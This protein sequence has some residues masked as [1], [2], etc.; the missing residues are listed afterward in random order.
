[1]RPA[2]AKEG[3][4]RKGVSRWWSGGVDQGPATR[5]RRTP[6]SASV[7]SGPACAALH[8]AEAVASSMLGMVVVLISGFSGPVFFLKTPPRGRIGMSRAT[9]RPL[10]RGTA[11]HAQ[12]GRLARRGRVGT[13]HYC[14]AP[15]SEPD[16][17]VSL[18][19]LK[20]CVLGS[21][22]VSDARGD[23][24]GAPSRGCQDRCC[25]QSVSAGGDERRSR[26][27]L[28]EYRRKRCIWHNALPDV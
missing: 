13:R 4:R 5:S 18:I 28:P 19:R 11:S 22:F 1:M 25:R 17:R 24:T 12:A 8:G 9:A 6:R 2:P 27:R 21:C 3:R 15:P 14:R 26:G 23:T 16:L 20:P 7:R 10:G